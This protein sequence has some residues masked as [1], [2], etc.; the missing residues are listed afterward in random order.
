MHLERICLSLSESILEE[1]LV[2]M[3]GGKSSYEDEYNNSRHGEQSGED[4]GRKW[5]KMCPEGKIGGFD[6][7]SSDVNQRSC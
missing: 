6:V 5:L 4:W 3:L 2:L 7:N 1:S